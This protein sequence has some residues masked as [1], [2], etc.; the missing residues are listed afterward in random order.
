MKNNYRLKIKKNNFQRQVLKE[1]VGE[2]IRLFADFE[3]FGK[4]T[5]TEGFPK[6]TML[7][8]N[9][10]MPKGESVCQHIW[11]RADE[12]RN[13]DDYHQNLKKNQRIAIEATPYGYGA[14][15]FGKIRN[16]KYS[17][18]NIKILAV[19]KKGFGNN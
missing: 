7:L 6:N 15:R 13:F 19:G 9:L 11:V 17:L 4:T 3:C 10:R 18:G 16:R 8:C 5:P 1:F 12:V 14:S 2:K